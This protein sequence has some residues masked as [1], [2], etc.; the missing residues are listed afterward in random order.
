MSQEAGAWLQSYAWPGNVRELSH[1]IERVTLLH[2]EVILDASSLERLCLGQ[3]Q[4]AAPVGEGAAQADSEPQ[5]EPARIRQ[6]LIQSGGNVVRAARLLGLSRDAV[7][8]RMRHY[9]IQRPLS[10]F[11]STLARPP[12]R[13]AT[14]RQS[15]TPHTAIAVVR[16]T[17]QG[18]EVA[19]PL[20]VEGMDKAPNADAAA[21][22]PTWEQKPV[23]VLAIEL[24]WP[25]TVESEVPRYEP[26]TV[27]TRWEQLIAEKVQGLGGVILQRT[28][29]LLLA[30]F[31]LPY[32]LEQLPQRAVQATLALRQLTAGPEGSGTGASHP[33]MRQAVHW[34]QVLVDSRAQAPAARLLPVGE[35]LA[36]PVRLLGQAA[37]GEI[38]VS[39]EVGRLVEAWCELQTC[40][41]L[42]GAEA[43]TVVGLRPQRTL[44]RMHGSHPLSRFV[45]RAHELAALQ[46]LSVQVEQGR[47]QVMALVGEPGVGKSRLCYE[48]IRA[49]HSQEWQ[50]HETSADSYGQATAYLPVIELLKAYFHITERDDG[51]T[52]HAKVSG[53]LLTLGETLGPTLPAFLTLLDVPIEDPAWQSLDPPQRRQRLLEAIKWLLLEVSRAQPLLL[54]IENLHWIDTETQAVLE[55]LIES[56]PA[57]QVFLLVTYRPEYQHAWGSKT[58]YT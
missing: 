24:T 3:P 8:Y 51:P 30:G 53:K 45:G 38:L 14:S 18:E 17:G 41:G 39:P 56:L 43:Y 5:D 32:T 28:P 37:V 12:G 36:L 9:G 25:V 29:S 1:L 33:A 11:S 7:R 42:R 21:L 44:L 20:V 46:A 27:V 22:V 16:K 2:P 49:H 57:A 52:M 4:P 15:I 48:F 58:Y 6:A 31:G 34:G 13:G 54:V 26:W 35:T 55:N 19:T 50:I 23:A 47:G 10:E 40:E